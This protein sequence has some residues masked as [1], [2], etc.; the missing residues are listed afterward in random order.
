MSTLTQAV[1]ELLSNHVAKDLLSQMIQL[2][3]IKTGDVREHCLSK[4]NVNGAHIGSL[5]YRLG[6]GR[7]GNSVFYRCVSRGH[8]LAKES[9][10]RRFL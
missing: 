5:E 6:P 3:H 9:A 2:K 10:P 1:S 8:I 7:R 4:V